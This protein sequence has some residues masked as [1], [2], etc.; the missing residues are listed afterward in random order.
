MSIFNHRTLLVAS[1]HQKERIVAPLFEKAFGSK[2]IATK[3]LDTDQ[4]GTFSGEIERIEDPISAARTKCEKAYEMTGI[5]LVLSSEGSFG[6]HPSFIFLPFNEEILLLK[7]FKHQLEILVRSRSLETNFNSHTHSSS[8]ELQ[9]FL[10]IVKFPAH[11]L[12]LKNASNDFSNMTK[13]I[14]S[15][16]QLNQLIQEKLS[17]FGTFFLETDMRA[18][19]NPTRRKHIRSAAIELIRKMKSLCPACDYPGFSVK[20]VERGLPCGDC[21]RPTSGILQWVYACE[22]CGYRKVKNNKKNSGLQ[23]PMY[24]DFCNP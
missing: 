4:M 14:S 23:D 11:Y 5:D 17:N 18:F 16:Q 1:K 24:C 10:R 20:E 8:K 7:D 2:V 19:A 3:D 21:L 12:I 9:E 13:G 22:A 15:Y 6:P